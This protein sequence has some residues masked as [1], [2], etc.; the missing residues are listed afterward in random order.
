MA[1]TRRTAAR[2]RTT[3][4]T[5]DVTRA[6]TGYRKKRDFALS[7]EPN[8][9]ASASG[10]RAGGRLFCVQKHLASHLH[11]DVRLEHCG[12]LL[13]WAVPKGPSLDPAVKRLAMQVEDHP[14]AYGA[15]EGVIPRGYGAG[16]VVMWDTGVWQPVVDDV[17]AALARGN[18]PFVVLG[19]KLAGAWSL[20]RAGRVG[21]AAW[22]LIKQRDE[23]ATRRDVTRNA[24]GSVVSEG[25]FA[26]VLARAVNDPW[27]QHPPVVGGA[28]GALF[29]QVI[30]AA[31]T[32]RSSAASSI[33]ARSRR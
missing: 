24:P 3:Q 13:S 29:R 30:T 2:E 15:F 8:G 25:D 21:P 33:P 6:L 19:R 9:S 28:T 27:P 12:V 16:I 26:E 32:L 22:L 10:G 7:P 11:Y 4:Q 5:R 31:R 17:D 23:W 18:L 20:I 14:V 1:S